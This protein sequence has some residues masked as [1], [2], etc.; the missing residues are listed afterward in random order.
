MKKILQRCTVALSC[1]K[2]HS[3]HEEHKEKMGREAECCREDTGLEGF[4]SVYMCTCVT[5]YEILLT[6]CPFVLLKTY[7][8][9]SESAIWYYGIVESSV[10]I[11]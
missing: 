8:S 3:L 1:V 10:L 9:V 5:Q 11:M 2:P 4:V 7:F 6:G